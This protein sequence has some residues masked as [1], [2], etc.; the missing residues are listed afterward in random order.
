MLF[1]R[2]EV[3]GLNVTRFRPQ[4]P[5]NVFCSLLL[6]ILGNTTDIAFHLGYFA[7]QFSEAHFDF[8]HV[9]LSD[10]RRLQGVSRNS[11]NERRFMF[12][13]RTQNLIDLLLFPWPP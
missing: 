1:A 11:Q 13:D 2:R 5:E 12:L 6:E 3:I 10:Q 7:V 9:S 4:P 8:P